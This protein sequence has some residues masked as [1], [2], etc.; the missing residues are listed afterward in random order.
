MTDKKERPKLLAELSQMRKYVAE[1]EALLEEDVDHLKEP[2]APV[3]PVRNY[4]PTV[5]CE[6]ILNQIPGLAY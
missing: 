3:A 2:Q 5:F 6:E 4:H 1:L